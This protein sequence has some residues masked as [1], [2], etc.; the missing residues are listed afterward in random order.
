MPRILYSATVVCLVLSAAPAR[1][2]Q[3]SGAVP[4]PRSTV[5]ARATPPRTTTPR[6]LPGTRPGVFSTIQGNA[7]DSNSGSLA[8]A[9]VRL[10]DARFGQIVEAQ[11][12]DQSGIFGFRAVDPGSYIVEIVGQNQYSVLAASQVLYVG[13]GEAVSA[14]VKL[15]FKVPPLAAVLGN[16]TPSAATVVTQAAASGVLAAQ[17]SGAPTCDTPK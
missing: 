17:A 2:Q 11:T 10:R 5:V 13:P 4:A 3:P 1:A 14:I 12:T 15:P 8:N 7:L 9:N 16:T 6:I